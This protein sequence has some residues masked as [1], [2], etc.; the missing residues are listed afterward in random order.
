M[1]QSWHI[2]EPGAPLVWNWHI[3][4]VCQHLQAVTDGRIKRLIINIP[5]GHMKSLLVSVF[6][7]AWEWIDQPHLRTLFSSYAMDLAIRDSMRCRDLV[8]SDW[9][10][11]SFDWR[12]RVKDSHWRLRDDQNAKSYFEN[13]QKGFRFSMSV[14]GRA[15]GFRGNKIVVDDPLN[16]KEMHSSAARKECLFWWDKVM[17]TRLNDP[18]TGAK[19]IIM[20]RLHEEDLT[21]HL[22]RRGGYEHLCLPTEFDPAR[23]SSTC[24]GWSDPRTVPGELLFPEMF[25]RV[26]VE[27]LK[28]DL[29][30][31]GYAG[32]HGQLPSPAEGGLFKRDWWRYYKVAP[33]EFD[34]MLQSWDMTFKDT[35]GSDFVVGQVWGRKGASKYLLD[36]VR[37][38]MGFSATC[39]AVVNLSAKWP[40]AVA[41]LIEDKANGPAVIDALSKKVS[42]LIAVE[43]QGGK[44][45]RAY[46]AQ[47]EAEAGNVYL[48]DPSIAPW[49]NDWV[50]EFAAFPNGLNDDQVDGYSQ[51]S[52]RWTAIR[53]LTASS[54]MSAPR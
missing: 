39:Q 30:S 27:G 10:I 24:I 9:Y 54:I 11:R 31:D 41:K 48:P 36:Q 43:P 1:R 51:M 26:V 3:D 49:I 14:G 37:D 23:A 20:Q 38:R 8:Q 17:P 47:P 18:R 25:N 40:N 12:W 35:D 22:L 16:A 44:L 15:T 53:I 32:Q 34:E 6:W 45:A 21:G 7:P 52:A 28:V 2:V 19:V 5:P 33:A 13:D 29:G 4:A 42:G 46:A 50:E